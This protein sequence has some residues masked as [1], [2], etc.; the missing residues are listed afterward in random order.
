MCAV[1]KIGASHD[2]IWI[3]TGTNLQ[4]IDPRVYVSG[5]GA[6]ALAAFINW[7]DPTTRW[8]LDTRIAELERDAKD[9]REQLA[10][11][12]KQLGAIDILASKGWQDRKKTGRPMKPRDEVV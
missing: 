8:E 9:L 3:D 11:A 6:A 5:K 7:T 12:D 4:D 2:D 1:L 10:E